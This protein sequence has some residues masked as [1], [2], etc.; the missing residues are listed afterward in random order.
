MMHVFSQFK[1]TQKEKTAPF[2][3]QTKSLLF[4]L[5]LLSDSPDLGGSGDATSGISSLLLSP[6][7]SHLTLYLIY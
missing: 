2:S 1:L 7:S 5:H 3:L 6:V 4:L